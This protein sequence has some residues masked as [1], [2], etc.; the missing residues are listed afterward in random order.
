VV[1]KLSSRQPNGGRAIAV[2]A[3]VLH[4]VEGNALPFLRTKHS[5]QIFYVS[6]HIG[7]AIVA[8]NEAE[9]AIVVPN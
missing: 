7:G 8:L 3:L 5:R 6:E 1:A 2:A 4:H 9:A